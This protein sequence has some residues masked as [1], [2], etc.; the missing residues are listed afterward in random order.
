MNEPWQV[1]CLDSKYDEDEETLVLLCFF[2]LLNQKRV[3]CLSRKDFHY[4]N[5]TD[6]PHLE[7]YKTAALFKDKTFNIVIEDDP[8]RSTIADDPLNSSYAK[9]V[10]EFTDR[11]KKELDDVADGLADEDKVVA[12]RI[13]DIV[14]EDQQKRN[15][16][17]SDDILA[18]EFAVR[19]KLH[20]VSGDL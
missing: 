9:C 15:K 6:V 17:N 18:N 3:I 16:L 14:K 2:H 8:H 1:T 4:K 11:I 20:N 7:M 19:A 10:K 13:A 12:R 5:Q